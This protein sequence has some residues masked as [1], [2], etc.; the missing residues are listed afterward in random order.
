MALDEVNTSYH[1]KAPFLSFDGLTLYFSRADGP[2]GH[3]ARIYHVSRAT[4]TGLFGTAQEIS[5]L[6]EAGGHVDY[7]WVSPDNLRL[8]YYS[9]GS[10]KRLRL[11]E[12]A[13]VDSAWPRGV[14][15]PELNALG[16]LANPTLTEDELV[17]VFSGHNLPGGRGDWDLW[18]AGRPSRQLPF[19]NVKHLR[20]LNTSRLDAHPSVTPDGLTLYFTSDRNGPAQIFRAQRGSRDSLF[21]GV[22]HLASLDTP[23]GGSYYPMASAEGTTL[24]FVKQSDGGF[25]DVYV[26]SALPTYYVDAAR[27]R[28][29]NSGLSPWKAFATIQKAIDTAADGDV[30]L[31]QPG[32]YREQIRFLGKAV[33]VQSAADAAVLEAPGG[34]AVSFYMGEG[35]D[36]VLRN[37]IIANSYIG[38]LC[39]RSAPTI[40]N[41]TVVGNVYGA[42]AYGGDTSRITNSILWGNTNSDTLGFEVTY[43]CVERATVGWS[44][45]RV[46]GAGTFSEDPLFVD[47][48]TGDYHVRS[49]RGRYWPEHDV[50]VLDDVTSPCVDAGDPAADF[51]AERKPNGRRINVGAHGGT[52]YAALSDSPFALDINGDGV[53][54]AADLE[55]YADL[56]EQ[57]TQPPVGPPARAR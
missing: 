31:V 18:M 37:L 36:T 21:G 8:Y 57:Q 17:I 42:E 25:A 1:D 39:A 5:S 19:G 22:Q 13:T 26:S 43:S 56:W 35:A 50:W 7:P 9:T 55:T 12:R 3:Y 52:A 32:V 16:D 6:N 54:D 27:G 49:E 40:T 47:P 4:S 24:Y 53:V 11:S 2:E 14:D 30:I 33:T 51:S 28:N 41:V 34:L 10:G 45:F 29:G 46:F 44:S 38:I 20:A 23:G 48:E 15:I